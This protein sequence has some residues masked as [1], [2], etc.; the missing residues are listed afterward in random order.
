MMR[1]NGFL[2]SLV[3]TVVAAAVATAP[4]AGATV[5]CRDGGGARVCQKPG[6]SSMHAKPTPR[7]TSGDLFSS[8]WL[9]GYGRGH[10]PPLIALD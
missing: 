3:A 1:T 8:A 6:H 2:A 9:P 10:L 5:A 4:A 7:G